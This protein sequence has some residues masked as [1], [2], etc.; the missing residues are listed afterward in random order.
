MQGHY[1]RE[2]RLIRWRNW[3]VIPAFIPIFIA[4][5]CDIYLE[6]TVAQIISRHFPDFLLVVFAVSVGVFSAA[7]D[8]ERGLEGITREHY[9]ASSGL[10]ALLSFATYFFLYDRS[11]PSSQLRVNSIRLIFVVCAIVIVRKGFRLEETVED[12]SQKQN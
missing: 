7:L 5:L 1:S 10:L 9:I 8:L 11:E 3:G 2:E 4:V 6:Y 12:Q